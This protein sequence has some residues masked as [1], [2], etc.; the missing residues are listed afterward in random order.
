[1][2]LKKEYWD[3]TRERDKASRYIL[4][5]ENGMEVVL[6]DFGALILSINLPVNGENRDVVLGFDTLGEYYNNGAG[7]GAYVGRNANRIGGAKVTI[8]GVEYQL[9]ENNNSNNLHSGQ[10]RSYYKFYEAQIGIEKSCA[11]VE[12]S[13]ISPHME[14]GFP[15]NLKQKIRYTLT[16]DNELILTYNMVSDQATVINPT[17]HCY[18]NLAGQGSGD[19]LGHTMTI[20]AD[21]FLPT[22]NQLIPTGKLC[23]V[24]GTPFDFR[25]AKK[26]GLH[27]D[28]DYEPLNQAGGY[29]HNFC[30][31]YDGGLKKVAELDSP[32]GDLTMITFTDLCGMQ[33]YTGNFLGGDHGKGGTTYNR[34][35]GIC[36]ET[37]FYPNACNDPNFLTS[38]RAANDPFISR[39]VYKFLWK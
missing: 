7:F 27:I 19:V 11:W 5:N 34:R 37:Q 32:N 22:D 6:S 33:V 14:Q 24:A 39:T 15:G 35:N 12:F 2:Q 4:T 1:M 25:R 28:E 30:L 9:E 18:F 21:S 23:P 20:Y 38:I 8:E 17:N 3:L 36:F 13:R 29:D 31:N 10:D 16:E 26:I